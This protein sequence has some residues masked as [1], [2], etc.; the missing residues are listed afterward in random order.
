M[1]IDRRLKQ[2]KRRQERQRVR[3]EERARARRQEKA[4]DYTMMAWEAF[5]N[6]DYKE[7]LAFALK[8]LDIVP[9]DMAMVEIALE[10]A[11]LVRDGTTHYHL[12]R[13]F[14]KSRL[15]SDREDYLLLGKMAFIREDVA[16]SREVFESLVREEVPLEKPLTKAQT[17]FVRSRLRDISRAEA[18][19]ARMRSVQKRTRA[20]KESAG[21]PAT[22]AQTASGGT[23]ANQEKPDHHEGVPAESGPEPEVVFR[24]DATELREHL[25]QLSGSALED[26]HLAINAYKLS[27]RTSYDQL[28]CIPTLRNVESI[29]YQEE[30]ARKVLKIFRGRAILADEVG[31]GKTIEAGLI[32]KEYLLR[33]LV[34]S[35]LVLTPSSLV[36]QWREELYEK[37]G[38]SFV[39]SNDAAFREGPA[40]FWKH[41]LIVAS[42]NTAK[43]ARQWDAVT[44]R[45]Y[46]LVIVDE[47]HHLKNRTTRNW[48]L[49]NAIQ[50]NF[51][52]LLTATPVEN[53][54]EELFNLV[55]LLRPGHLKTRKAFK[56]EFVTRGNPTDPRNRDRLRG[57]LKEVM[58]RNTRSVTQLHLPPRFATTIR[59]SPTEQEARFYREVSAFVADQAT[60]TSNALSRRALQRL[61]AAAG[62][63]HWAAL[64]MLE[65]MTAESF[66]AS[67]QLETMR[68]L[69]QSIGASAKTQRVIQ[70]LLATPDQTILF[71]NTMATLEHVHAVLEGERIS[72]AVFCGT[73]TK[74]QK[75]SALEAFRTGC[76]VLLAT[77][78]GGEGHNL[79]FC[80]R[81]INYDL[82]WNPMEI[83]QRIGRIHRIGQTEEV[84]I[85]NFCG[86]GTVEDY[87]LEVLDRKI[88]MFELVIGEIDMIL[89]R[90]KGEQEF[91]QLVYDLW[92]Q[93]QDSPERRKAFADLALRLRRARSAYEKS[94]ELDEG[95]FQEDFGI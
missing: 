56:A 69:G 23:G 65:G 79:Q 61:L 28:L 71:V 68:T 15:L 22:R 37:F 17:N 4:E 85:Y 29:W 58:I 38:L 63:S 52:V 90:L 57:L 60:Q 87:V 50:K 16:L 2:K 21:K 89:G 91:D 13:R 80:R 34:R 19:A 33:G 8:R 26:F 11:R 46:D 40:R 51:L 36:N 92:I 39:S 32:L 94:K 64:R 9:A 18:L 20:R 53:N 86:A 66:D 74:T 88:N 6:D 45:A 55:T 27:F 5:E 7:A 75:E 12:L 1:A 30:T 3:R 14:W 83:E 54:L 62:S 70:L 47:A 67:R 42:I 84:Q 25:K 72:H 48:K 44:S 31:L 76:P 93:H 78:T 77:G 95:L 41:P 59:V 82:P 24:V 10:T 49:V 43:S 35:V 73:L 81:M